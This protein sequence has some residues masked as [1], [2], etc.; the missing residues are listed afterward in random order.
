MRT[1]PRQL[2]R[3]TFDVVVIGA[4]IHGAAI[5]RDAA[6]RG[7]SV[8]LVDECDVAAGASART[9]GV[10]AAGLRDLRR[11][12]FASA[13][14][15]LQE[16]ERLLRTAPHLVRP[17]PMLAPCFD[18]ITEAP[19]KLRIAT[20]LASRLAKRSTLPR[21]RRL[22]AAAALAAFPGLDSRG[23]RSGLLFFEARVQDA[24]LT[25]ANVQDAV[26]AGGLFCNHA[27]VAACDA[28]GVTLRAAGDE[29]IVKSRV[30]VNAAGASVDVVRRS[31]GVGGPDLVRTR[32]VR[33]VVVPARPG[34][35]ALCAFLPGDR[36]RFVV[37]HA[38]G[39][40]C[41]A[42]DAADARASD[43][44]T[45]Q[46]FE[47]I[48]ASFA[49]LLDPCPAHGEIGRT[50][51]SWRA[52]PR[53]AGGLRAERRRSFTVSEDVP[54]GQV[55]SVVGGRFTTHRSFAER[56]VTSIFGLSRGSPTR[57]RPLPGGDG[58]REVDD[59]LWWRHGSR[60]SELRASIAAEPELG[61]RLCEHRPFLAAELIDAVERHGAVTFA[62]A[63]LRRLVDVRGP[64]TEPAC[65]QRALAVFQRAGGV[66][67]NEAQEIVAVV[68][69]V[70]RELPGLQQE[71]P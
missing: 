67:E 57:T 65:M 2:H 71:I 3:A 59:D 31:L 46:H 19:A 47:E 13:R 8:L 14:E 68:D 27:K 55:H 70:R 58:P 53:A 34:E 24:R 17:L 1:D 63:M 45:R 26:A 40:I 12:L 25:L 42:D 21:P 43:P 48:C 11:G 66:V 30:L 50:V 39:A 62:D 49:R 64:C 37:P 22:T 36:E 28:D 61:A 51:S 20:T 44:S 4:G 56:A 6:L 33:H 9:S 52:L 15:A 16:R 7:L 69:G 29:V 54:C 60:V 23:L 35:L 5:A 10:M 38:G 32:R 18:G 41:G